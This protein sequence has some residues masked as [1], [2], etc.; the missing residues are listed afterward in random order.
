MSRQPRVDVAN[1]IYHVVNRSNARW[2]IFKTDK[3]YQNVLDSLEE[4]LEMIPIDIFSFCLMPNHWHFS[5]RPKQDGDMGKFFGKFTQKATQRW[6]AA[7]HTVGSGHL[8]QGRFKSFLVQQDPYFLQLMKY[9]EANALRA[10][11]VKKAEDWP[12]SS[13]SIRINNP[14]YAQKLLIAWPIDVPKNYLKL[15]N[16]PLPKPVLKSLRHSIERG[17]P[18]GNDKWVGQ[19]IKKHNL[20]YTIRPVGRP[21]GK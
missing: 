19:Q 11:M 5:V 4:T 12:W 13:L 8:F 9:I 18:L 2:T 1:E 15:V 14:Q 6:H 7:H 17:K 3:D 21:R 20:T 10:K 16:E